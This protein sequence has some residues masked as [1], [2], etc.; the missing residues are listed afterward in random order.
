MQRTNVVKMKNLTK[1][2]IGIEKR[3]KRKNHDFQSALQAHQ[4]ALHIRI[5]LFGEEHQSTADC[6]NELGI[7]HHK[8]GDFKAALQSKQ[9]ELD[10]RIKLFGEEHQSTALSYYSLGMTQRELGDF[11]AAL[12]SYQRALDIRIKLFGEEH[13]VR[14]IY[15]LNCLERNTKVRLA[16]TTNWG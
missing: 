3:L 13:Q 11:K 8:M 15:V 5:K 7:T 10:I 6:Y 4:R 12:Q 9:R 1:N 2:K 16:V 14:W